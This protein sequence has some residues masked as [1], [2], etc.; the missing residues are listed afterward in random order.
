[1]RKALDTRLRLIFETG[2]RHVRRLI[3]ASLGT[4][5]ETL[6]DWRRVAD[7]LLQ[8]EELKAWGRLLQLLRK[9]TD[10][11]QT[12]DPVRELVEFVSR[13]QFRLNLQAVTVAIPD[14]LLA[15]RAAPSGRFVLTLTPVGGKPTEYAF[16]QQGEPKRDR[17]YTFYTFVPDNHSNTLT[18]RPGDG[19][20]AALPIRAATDDYRL[21]WSSGRSVVY[22]LDRLW[23]PPRLEKG[24]LIPVTEPAPGV[25]LTV[26]PPGGLPPVPVLLPDLRPGSPR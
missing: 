16:R 23:Q 21:L 24:G 11:S 15:Q 22:Q 8:E 25:R 26:A 9:W 18:Y 5:P 14:D 6:T 10:P 1:V 12:A 3:G 4:G 19:L 13:D 17:P 2:V 20:N 7:G